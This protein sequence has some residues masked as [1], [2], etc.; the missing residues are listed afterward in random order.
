M[1]ICVAAVGYE[2]DVGMLKDIAGEDNDCNCYIKYDDFELFKLLIED[3]VKEI[4]E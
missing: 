4:I 3:A 1:R 2:V